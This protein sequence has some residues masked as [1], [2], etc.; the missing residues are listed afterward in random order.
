MITKRVVCSTGIQLNMEILDL[1]LCEPQGTNFPLYVESLNALAPCFF[2]L[3]RQNCDIWIPVHIRDMESLPVAIH[4]EFEE[5]GNWVF[6][7]PHTD[8]QAYR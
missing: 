1:I 7:R 2:A 5:H 3:D 4:K 8:S 6:S